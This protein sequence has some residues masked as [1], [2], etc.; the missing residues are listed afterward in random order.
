V[1][2]F[3]LPDGVDMCG[4]VG[5]GRGRCYMVVGGGDDMCA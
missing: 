3:V 2:R 4:W 1:G 5:A